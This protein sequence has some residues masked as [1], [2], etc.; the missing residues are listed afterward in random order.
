MS[1]DDVNIILNQIKEKNIELS[2]FNKNIKNEIEILTKKLYTICNHQ[3]E[4]D[5]SN[6]GEHTEYIC[7]KCLLYKS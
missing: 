5:Y 7:S 1:D 2:N 6:R 4:I 3:W